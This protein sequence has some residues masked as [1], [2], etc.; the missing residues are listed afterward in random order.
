MRLVHIAVLAS[1]ALCWAPAVSRGA[2]AVADEDVALNGDEEAGRQFCKKQ[3]AGKKFRITLPKDAELQD[4]VNWM[5]TISCQRF[6]LDS[7]LRASKITILSPEPVSVQEAYA[8]FYAALNS[9]GLTVEPSGRYF[10]IVE[11]GKGIQNRNLPVY[12]PDQKAPDNDRFVTQLLRPKGVATADLVRLL[13]SLKSRDGAVQTVGDLII[14]TDS[15]SN[16]RRLMRITEEIDQESSVGEKIFFFQLQYADPEETAAT[17]REIFGEGATAGS[18]AKRAPSGS[19]QNP[20]EP[21]F[22]RV[23]VDE[24]TGTLVIVAREADYEVI[25]RLIQRLDVQLAGGGGRIHVVKLKN[26]DP[27]EV[28]QVL[29]QLG[30]G[31]TGGSARRGGRNTSGSTPSAPAGPVGADLFSG[32]V[33]VTPDPS[34]RSLVILASNADFKALKKV[35]EELDAERKQLFFEIYLLELS[36]QR[37]IEAGAGGHFGAPINTSQGQGL[38]FVSSAPGSQNAIQL[39]PSVLQGLAG[40][41]IGPAIP[42]SAAFLGPENTRDIPAF[43][44]VIQALQTNSD[45]NFVAEPH[46]YTADNKE[47]TIKVGR[48]VPTPGTLGAIGAGA[49]AALGVAAQ[50]INRQQIALEIKIT[51]HVN[52]EHT[53]TL[54]IEL[55]NN[56]IADIHPQLGVSTTDRELK[57]EGVLASDDQPVV[58]GGLT[59]EVERDTV[60]QVPGLGSIPILGWLFK[61]KKR[62]RQ[63][64]NLMII[65]V[66]HIITSPDDR[67]RIYKQRLEERQEFME[68]Y[69]AF[70]RRDLRTVVNYR[71]KSGLLAEVNR[72]ADRMRREEDFMQRADKELEQQNISGEIGLSPGYG[73]ENDGSN[74]RGDEPMPMRPTLPRG[75]G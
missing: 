66:P 74:D 14:I 7:S 63:Q 5:M 25:R 54:D 9:M 65:L 6:I 24:R 72:E 36:S 55:R 53:V 75:A 39:S 17:V 22:S 31:A 52:D 12:G 34:T 42:N 38:G 57:L 59:Q 2:P 1:T 40:G 50:S 4:L 69:T 64:V 47:G 58:L 60:S 41:V 33:K 46:I 11:L 18:K 23:V 70:K 48:T 37:S 16:V 19:T 21:S 44:V 13:E 67:R 51:P 35:I 73:K 61:S 29:N 3:P 8:A 62:E 49:G 15:G 43:G 68:R 26:A 45:V 32:D 10:K 27:E 28:A 56:D 30:Q 71:K 20:D